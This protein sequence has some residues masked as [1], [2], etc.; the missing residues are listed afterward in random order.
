MLPINSTYDVT[1]QYSPRRA[2]LRGYTHHEWHTHFDLDPEEADLILR[3]LHEMRRNCR[4]RQNAT[5]R[6]IEVEPRARGERPP[7][8]LHLFFKSIS[9]RNGI[10]TDHG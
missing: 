1:Y 4:V 5:G 9:D 3:M 7:L 6:V 2:S 10:D 8:L